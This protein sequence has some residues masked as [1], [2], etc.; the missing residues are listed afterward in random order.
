MRRACPHPQAHLKLTDE[1]LRKIV[2]ALPP[3]L[4]LSFKK[5]VEPKLDALQ[6]RHA[7]ERPRAHRHA[8][9]HTSPHAPPRAQQRS[10]YPALSD[11]PPARAPIIAVRRACPHPQAHLKLTDEQLR[12]I[13]VANPHVLSYSLE[14]RYLPRIDATQAAKKD[15]MMVIHKIRLC[16]SRFFALLGR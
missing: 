4:S 12:K 13:V 7:T 2:V 5:N 8:H 15:L 1:Q 14:K 11:E 9:T 10:S 16:D 3:V 6:V